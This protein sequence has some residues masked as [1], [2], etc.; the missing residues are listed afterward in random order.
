MGKL[1]RATH[2]QMGLHAAGNWLDYPEAGTHFLEPETAYDAVTD[3]QPIP[4]DLERGDGQEYAELNGPKI[5]ELGGLN[6]PLYGLSGGGAGDGVDS[7]TLGAGPAGDLLTALMGAAPKDFTG[8]A[9]DAAPGVGATATL[10]QAP[11][12]LA[13]GAAVALLGADSN[14]LQGRF[15]EAVDGADITLCRALTS[16]TGVAENAKAS[17]PVYAGRVWDMD[18]LNGDHQHVALDWEGPD[19]RYRLLGLLGNGQIALPAGGF[20]RIVTSMTGCDWKKLAKA[21]PDFVAPTQGTHIRTLHSPLYV[22]STP[23]MAGLENIDLGLALEPREGAGAP[24][25]LFGQVVVRKVPTFTFRLS[26]GDLTAPTELTEAILDTWRGNQAAVPGTFDLLLQLG[27]HAGG[28]MLVR[29]RAAQLRPRRV[30]QGG[31]WGA[32]VT[33]RATRP[34]SGSPFSIVML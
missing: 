2:L 12:D 33:A 28:M 20:A 8:E 16:T 11:E 23:Y 34:A 1:T 14:E 10:D 18:F 31:Q 32:T 19:F 3:Y 26:A 6:L 29:F 5:T 22:G 9:T 13:A 24:N 4:R 30:R 25:D 7:E 17:T 21:N 15:V 27:R